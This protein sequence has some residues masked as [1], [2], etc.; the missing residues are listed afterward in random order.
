MS[1]CMVSGLFKQFNLPCT[2]T[3]SP[4]L[5]NVAGINAGTRL[6]ILEGISPVTLPRFET[7][8]GASRS[9]FK[10]GIVPG[11]LPA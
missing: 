5:L 1:H 4:Y 6:L 11:S 8:K 9:P 3:V 10:R 7:R 2:Q